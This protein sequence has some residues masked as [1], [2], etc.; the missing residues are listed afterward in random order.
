METVGGALE[1]ISLTDPSR[2]AYRPTTRSF[3]VRPL[4]FWSLVLPL[5]ALAVTGLLAAA[6]PALRATRV[7]PVIALRYE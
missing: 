1:D 5:G 7:D 4:E 2:H 3:E 6:L